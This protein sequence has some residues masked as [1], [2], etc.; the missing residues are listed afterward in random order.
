VKFGKV[1]PEVG[2]IG[3]QITDALFALHLPSNKREGP[4][5]G[6]RRREHARQRVRG[7]HLQSL[8]PVA[9]DQPKDGQASGGKQGSV[10]LPAGDYK[11]R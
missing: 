1:T 4:T 11:Y 5:L 9:F 6:R 7:G 2:K 3:V 8:R 10:I